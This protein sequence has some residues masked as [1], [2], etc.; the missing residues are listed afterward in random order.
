MARTVLKNE[1]EQE[2]SKIL[3]SND[4][5]PGRIGDFSSKTWNNVAI[6]PKMTVPCRLTIHGHHYYTVAVIVQFLGCQELPENA[7]R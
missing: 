2:I 3:L 5:V 1:D 7:R 4:S 6:K